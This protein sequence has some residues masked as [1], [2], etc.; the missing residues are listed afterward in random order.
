MSFKTPLLLALLVLAGCARVSSDTK[1][2]PD[3]SFT[4]TV[5]YTVTKGN[6]G[7]NQTSTVNVAFDVPA[8]GNGV[9][10]TKKDTTE[11][12]SIV[13]TRSVPADSAPLKDIVVKDNKGANELASQ[14]SVTKLPDGNLEYT[15]TLHWTGTGSFKN[16]PIDA[17]LRTQIKKAMPERFQ[18]TDLIDHLTQ[19]V[20]ATVVRLFFGAPDPLILGMMNPDVLQYKMKGRLF[21]SLSA[22]LPN[23]LPGITTDETNQM[24]QSMAQAVDM[25]KMAQDKMPDPSKSQTPTSTEAGATLTF[26]VDYPGKVVKTNGIVDEADGVVYWSLLDFAVEFEDVKLDAIVNPKG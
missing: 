13:V 2:N 16:P 9:T 5:T 23:D 8:E 18:K 6:F 21:R 14:V 7:G 15:E 19:R 26:A 4:R 3:G 12:S 1:L 25:Q 10:I 17:G 11:N 24:I 22:E 20:M